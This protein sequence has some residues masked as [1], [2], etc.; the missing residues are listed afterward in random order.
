MGLHREMKQQ[1]LVLYDGGQEILSILE[2]REEEG[3]VTM[4]L[5]GSMRSDTAHD[6]LDELTAFVTLGLPL[7]MDLSGVDYLSAACM[8][9]LLAV[10]QKIDER[11]GR[12]LLRNLPQKVMQELKKSGMSELLM[13]EEK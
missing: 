1:T 2:Q 11:G 12:L 9:A 6:L 7:T 4:T 8:Q 3:G 13:I 5:T 10:Q